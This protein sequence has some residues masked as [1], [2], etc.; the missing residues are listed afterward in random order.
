MTARFSIRTGRSSR[1]ALAG[2]AVATVAMLAT[3]EA[4]A[5][6]PPQPP[7]PGAAATCFMEL[8][9]SLAAEEAVAASSTVCAEI[10]RLNL[11]GNHHVQISRQPDGVVAKVIAR[12]GERSVQLRVARIDDVKASAP[13]LAQMMARE[14]GFVPAGSAPPGSY[15]ASPP[16]GAAPPAAGAAQQPPAAGPQPAGAADPPRRGGTSVSLMAGGAHHRFYGI[17]LWLLGLGLS[18]GSEGRTFAGSFMTHYWGGSTGA[19]RSTHHVQL[20]GSAEAILGRLRIGGGGGFAYLNVQRAEERRRDFSLG[21]G[22]HLLLKVDV[23]EFDEHALFIGARLDGAWFGQEPQLWGG[24][25]SAGL[26]L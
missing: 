26:R 18:V 15:V 11:P 3:S 17:P 4:R 19:G 23:I 6:Q 9:P 24:T 20:G 22:V 16:G 13:E 14:Q 7:Q 5:Q 1:F 10:L 21:L 25:L 12:P 2:A 8:Q